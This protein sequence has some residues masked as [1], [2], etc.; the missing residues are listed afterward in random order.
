MNNSVY[1]FYIGF[2]LLLLT[3]GILFLYCCRLRILTCWRRR[4]L[5]HTDYNQNDSAL[6]MKNKKVNE[7]KGEKG[8]YPDLAG[9]E[10]EYRFMNE[11]S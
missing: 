3:G 5:S 4:T 7:V 6:E 2:P 10:T 8:L 11:K 1:F 9:V